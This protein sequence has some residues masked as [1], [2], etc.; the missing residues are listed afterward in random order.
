MSKVCDKVGACVFISNVDA[1]F[2]GVHRG[3]V[4]GGAVSRSPKGSDAQ[5]IASSSQL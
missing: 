2:C 4:W 1:V 5:Y 3:G